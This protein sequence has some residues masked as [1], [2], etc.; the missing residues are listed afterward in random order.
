MGLTDLNSKHAEQAPVEQIPQELNAY[1]WSSDQYF[2]NGR[3][4][5]AYHGACSVKNE[6][7]KTIQRLIKA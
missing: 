6:S 1:S 5:S 4:T 7:V 3:E 2:A